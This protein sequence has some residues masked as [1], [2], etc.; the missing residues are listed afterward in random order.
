MGK[1]ICVIVLDLFKLDEKVIHCWILE[2]CMQ[3]IGCAQNIGHMAC[4][5]LVSFGC[6]SVRFPMSSKFNVEYWWLC[7]FLGYRV[8]AI[9]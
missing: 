1:E 9:D 5:I 7:L 6:F 4:M 3:T 2:G 8:V